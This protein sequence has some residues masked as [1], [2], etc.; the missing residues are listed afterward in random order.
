MVTTWCTHCTQAVN[1]E[2]QTPLQIAGN[3]RP[4]LMEAAGLDADMAD[5][6]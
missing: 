3:L 6:A 1:K 4:A 2:E 5:A